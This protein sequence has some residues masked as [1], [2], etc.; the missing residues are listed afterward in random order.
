[1]KTIDYI[2]VGCGLAGIAFCEQL[3]AANKTFLVFD[4]NS[5]HSSRVA[6][7]LYN[8]VVLKRFTKVWKAKTQLELALPKYKSLEQF[9]DVKLDHKIPVYRKFASIEEQNEW[10]IASDKPVLSDFLSINLVNNTNAAISA[11][12]GFGEVLYS[13]R[14]NTTRLVQSYSAYLKSNQQLFEDEFHYDLLDIQSDFIQYKTIKAKHIIF[15][16]GYG[17]SKNPFFNFLPLNGTKGEM[18]TIKAPDLNMDFI[19]KSSVFIVPLENDLYW[20]GATYEWED[21]TY[22][23]TNNA[24]EELLEKVKQIIN[25]DFEV[26]DQVAGIR[27]TTKDRR[28][29]IGSHPNHKNMFVL[30]GLGT[31]GVMMSPYVAEQLFN[32]IEKGSDLDREID[33]KRFNA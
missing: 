30:N 21:K 33:I 18:L 20:I 7:G 8:P 27:P 12:Y 13:G 1:M 32:H 3:R 31:R 9:L 5:Q 23:I 28:P 4:N 15:A 29:L 10:F 19:L 26:V 25:C 16:E 17:L 2:I 14:I 11:K 24:K 6:A 22:R